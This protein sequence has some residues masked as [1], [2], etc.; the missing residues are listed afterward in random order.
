[1]S[2]T[3]NPG[4]TET[5][6]TPKND[7]TPTAP[8]PAPKTEDTAVED[9]KKQLQQQELRANQLANQLK[10]KE[11]AEA[12]AKEKELEEQNQYKDL[13]EQEKAK[14]EALET[15]QETEKRQA[16]L[17]EAKA[18]TLAGFSDDVKKAA[19][20]LGLTLLDTDES[21]VEAFKEK[22]A[23]LQGE[24]SDQNPVT[25]NNPNPSPQKVELT[26]DQIRESLAGDKNGQVFH[27]LVTK[28]YPGIAAMTKTGK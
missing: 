27:D 22:L 1:M 10:A 24:S 18:E 6:V 23:V 16:E 21:S 13:F 4:E 11:E 28:N 5:T 25:P 9:L 3:P 8:A 15:Q 12:K 2:D 7:A 14:R 26:P 19:E 20:K 17:E